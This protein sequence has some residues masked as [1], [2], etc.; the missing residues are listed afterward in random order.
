VNAAGEQVLVGGWGYLLG[1]E[2]SGAWIGREAVRLIIRANDQG[3]PLSALAAAVMSD[4]GLA[5]PREVVPWL[6]GRTPPP[7][8]ELAALVPR[9]LD[10]A[11][12]DDPDATRI[13]DAAAAALEE[14]ARLL[15]R[16]LQLDNAAIAL[17]GGLLQHDNALSRRVCARLGLSTIPLTRYSPALGAALLAKLTWEGKV[18]DRSD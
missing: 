7:I 3:T 2:G 18:N 16:R 10:A 17:A 13:L 4:L 8:K 12:S 5:R 15:Q 1:D 11:D 9:V 14:L 6:Y